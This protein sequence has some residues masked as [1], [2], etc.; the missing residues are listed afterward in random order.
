MR[1]LSSVSGRLASL[2][3]LSHATTHV[4]GID[5]EHIERVIEHIH[6]RQITALPRI[7]RCA[8]RR[9]LAFEPFKAFAQHTLGS[10]TAF[11]CE[12]RRTE[13][14]GTRYQPLDRIRSASECLGHASHGLGQ[15]IRQRPH[16][17]TQAAQ[18]FVNCVGRFGQTLIGSP[19]A[20]DQIPVEHARGLRG[21]LTVQGLVQSLV[22]RRRQAVGNS[23]AGT[24]ALKH[25]VLQRLFQFIR[26][27]HPRVLL[28]LADQACRLLG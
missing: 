2:T 7:I 9:R 21:F 6:V 14:G 26:S 1:R 3:R 10:F 17:I 13:H 18:R 15:S 11:E 24:L 20:C 27:T 12:E 28:N 22:L 4:T 23:F 16:G 5:D 19:P 25:N 8:H